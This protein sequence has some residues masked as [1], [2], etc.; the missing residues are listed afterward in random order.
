MSGPPPDP[1][2]PART[3]NQRDDIRRATTRS[4]A[5]CNCRS[6]C[7]SSGPSRRWLMSSGRSTAWTI[8]PSVTLT[9]TADGYN[10][11]TTAVN[12][13]MRRDV[14][15]VP[16]WRASGVGDTV[17]DMP[18]VCEACPH[19]GLLSQ[20]IVEL[21][22]PGCGA[23]GRERTT[24][25]DVAGRPAVRRALHHHRRTRR[26]HELARRAVGVHPGAV[27]GRR[28]ATDGDRGVSRNLTSLRLHRLQAL[29]QADRTAPG[30]QAE[31][32]CPHAARTGRYSC[33]ASGASPRPA[34]SSFN[35]SKDTL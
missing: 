2:A 25:D 26:D 12:A 7:H 24:R 3:S 19:Q 4:C 20:P 30:A 29:M 18:D 6:R 11:Q 16:Y 10:S 23:R 35:R 31:Q 17:F 34:S 22:R 33:S 8:A 13:D 1:R 27:S 15:L 5:T 28:G 21:H 14:R 32:A 9:Y